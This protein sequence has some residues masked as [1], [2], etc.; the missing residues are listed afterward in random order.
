MNKRKIGDKLLNSEYLQ[1]VHCFGRGG[2]YLKVWDNKEN[3]EAFAY[4]GYSTPALDYFDLKITFV[5]K[6]T[7]DSERFKILGTFN[8]KGQPISVNQFIQR[9]DVRNYIV[10]LKVS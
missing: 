7:F 10:D 5:K 1:K 2:G 3:V 6:D 4:G 8:R 9:N